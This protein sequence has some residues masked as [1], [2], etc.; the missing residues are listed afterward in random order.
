MGRYLHLPR[1]GKRLIYDLTPFGIPE[2]PYLA[3]QNLP[4]TTPG[5]PWHIHAGRMEINHFLKGERVYR[6]EDSDY[7]L[8]GNQ[9][10]VTWPDEEHGSGSFLHGRGL[11][12]WAQIALPRPGAPFLG[13]DA[14]TAA[15]L[16][17]AIWNLP[18]RQFHAD[19]ALRGLYSRILFICR[20]GLSR[21]ARVEIAALFAEW[22]LRIVAG[23]ENHRADAVT[24]DIAKALGMTNDVRGVPRSVGELA[25]AACLSESHFKLKFK[26]QLGVPP[27]E[28]LLRRRTEA[29]ARLL[30]EG[31]MNVTQIAFELGFSSSQHFSTTFRKFFGKSP[32]E[33]VSDS[34]RSVE[35][36]KDPADSKDGAFLPWIEDGVFHG[37][38][39]EKGATR[40]AAG[41]QP[42]KTGKRTGNG[43]G[44]SLAA[45]RRLLPD[46]K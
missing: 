20:Q 28:Y 34:R 39:C 10:F 3:A 33:W 26:Q 2:V 27:G 46:G 29:G 16:L 22:L 25:D 35:A 41:R 6:V 17:D 9:V 7:H 38:I 15:P 30:V 43:N 14:G 37:Y 31:K 1:H 44:S 11:H 8:T 42:F 18:R 40:A 36:G 13:F 21:L 19:P 32:L 23:S 12:F 5:L 4:H 24:P 45:S